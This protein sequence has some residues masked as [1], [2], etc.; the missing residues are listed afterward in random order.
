M[1]KRYAKQLIQMNEENKKHLELD[2]EWILNIKNDEELGKQVRN[3]MLEKIKQMNEYNE[4]IKKQ[5]KL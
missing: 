2:A 1:D 4:Q 3:R 5:I